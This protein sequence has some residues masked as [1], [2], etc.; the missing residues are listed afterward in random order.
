M[1]NELG[2]LSCEL[3]IGNRLF[4]AL[5]APSSLEIL[6]KAAAGSISA[7]DE[8]KLDLFEQ[9]FSDLFSI[10]TPNCGRAYYERVYGENRIDYQLYIQKMVAGKIRSIP[11]SKES[12]GTNM[13]LKVF[14]YLICAYVGGTV[15]LDEIDS[16]IHDFLFKDIIT[17][18]KPVLEKTNGQLI[19][20]THN[21]ALLETDFARDSAY[22]VEQDNIGH[23][24]AYCVNN[25][26]GRTYQQNNV[27]SK[28]LENAYGG[29]PN[30][31]SNHNMIDTFR[32]FVQTMSKL[33]SPEFI[34]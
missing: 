20:T 33:E 3:G 30:M 9:L 15:I 12:T 26:S 24:S 28:Y 17:S 22:I 14:C 23:R 29:L 5:N 8:P 7:D 32:T 10:V 4:S 34:D 13:L 19:I 18:I 21:T 1:L 27:R 6:E 16:E 11:F 2:K 25:V 31:K